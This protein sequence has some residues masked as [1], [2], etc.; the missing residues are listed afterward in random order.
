MNY[1]EVPVFIKCEINA[2]MLVIWPFLD[3][4]VSTRVFK[5]NLSYWAHIHKKPLDILKSK[6]SVKITEI[7]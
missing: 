5:W 3:T 6:E 4:K 1:I 7:Y 2:D